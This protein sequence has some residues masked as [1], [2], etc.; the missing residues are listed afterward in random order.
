M[1]KLSEQIAKLEDRWGKKLERLLDRHKGKW[2][3]YVP[4]GLSAWYFYGMLINS[5]R[6]GTQATFNQ[7]GEP[8]GSIWVVNPF[9]NFIAVFTPTGIAVTLVGALL[10]CLITKKG[11]V[12][13]SGY[14]FT[15]DNRG[16]DILPDGTHGTSGFMTKKEQEKIVLTGSIKD[17]DRTL[18]G[19]RKDRPE[20]DDK[21]AE[22]I[23]LKPG[24]GLTEH[25]MIYG[26]TGSGKTR[27]FV[28][29]FILQTARRKESMVLVDPKGEI[30]ESMSAFLKEQGYEV[31]MFNLLDMANSDAWNCLSEIEKDKDLV[32]SIAEV[33]IKNTS[34]ANERQDF[35]EK[36]ELNLLMA[37][38][39][40]VA[41]QTIPGTKDLLPIQQRSLGAIYRMLSNESFADLEKRFQELPKDHPALPPYGIFKLANRQIWG[42]IAIGLGNRLS[43]FQNP[44]VDKI[45]SYNEIDLTLPGKKPC[46]YFCCISAQDSSLEFLS[47]L[48]FSQLFTRLMDY[49]R[50]HGDHGRLPVTVN[51][52]LEEFCNI[53]KLM[54]FKRVLNVCRGSAI[55]CQII[56][57]SIP[58]LQDRYPKTEWEELIGCTD[59]QI[60]L[61]CN[62][63]DTATYIS[64]KCGMVT[65]KVENNQMPLMPLFSPVY[66]STRPYSQT[67]S[68]TQRPLMYPDE[69]MRMDN[70]ECLVLLRGQKPLRLYKII[71]DEHPSFGRLRDVRVSDYIPHWRQEE[72]KPKAKPAPS[73][74][75]SCEQEEV[76]PP[77]SSTG[78]PP[79]S[80]EDA[81]PPTPD[82]APPPKTPGEW[83][84]KYDYG[85]LDPVDGFDGAGQEPD[86]GQ[87]ARYGGFD[88]IE[89]EPQNVGGEQNEGQR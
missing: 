83:G 5:I 81:A 47:S 4:I 51:V 37:L 50:R 34:N 54:D 46:A 19:K 64:K 49:G 28:K 75:P 42:N 68:S 77:S 24:S 27:G 65:I 61:G 33:V 41:S 74:K 86:S 15:R 59:I 26:A 9:R 67:K 31:R 6:L 21:Y 79:P 53:G 40:Y 66:T 73:P 48:F 7:T 70:Q 44:L 3:L 36:A 87:D 72:G 38:M 88:L 12:W 39:H 69:I 20:D 32:Q 62:D 1:F 22:Y 52:C 11:Y 16:F 63:V 57:Q 17:L 85:L 80:Q 58:Q 71:P 23:T 78:S 45:T 43:V 2:K 8:V 82:S 29:P 10:V 56:V 84:P 55:F 18:L 13:F 76:P 89:T 35:W 25:T 14:K 30:Y 60:C